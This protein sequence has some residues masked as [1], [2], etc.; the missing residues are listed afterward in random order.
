MIRSPIKWFGGKSWLVEKI[1]SYIPRECDVV[2]EAFGGGAWLTLNL[3]LGRFQT[4]ICNDINS[5]LINFWMV[6]KENWKD[7]SDAAQYIPDSEIVYEHFEDCVNHGVPYMQKLPDPVEYALAFFYLNTHSYSGIHTGFHGLNFSTPAQ[8]QKAYLSK[9]GLFEE[10]WSRIQHVTFKST[11]VIDLLKSADRENVFIY[12][13]PPYFQGGDVYERIQ[14]GKEWSDSDFL[15]LRGRLHEMQH[16][17]MLISI[18]Q[19]E[20]FMKDGW[21][22]EEIEKTKKLR[23]E[24]K[25]GRETIVTNFKPIEYKPSGDNSVDPFEF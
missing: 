25:I 8:N 2:I 5:M 21:Y 19:G 3:P 22:L 9:I 4:I 13:D 1:I 16:A 24:A 15:R 17:K 23:A 18:D 20:Y 12:L 10:I 11:D 6:L 14:G 7:L